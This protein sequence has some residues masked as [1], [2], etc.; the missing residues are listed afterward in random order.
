MRGMREIRKASGRIAFW[1]LLAVVVPV[2]LANAQPAEF[3]DF[4]G[5]VSAITSDKM[6][7]DNRRGDRVS[8]VRSDTTAVTGV[9]QSW[10]AI[11]VGDSVTVSWKMTDQPRIAHKVVVLPAK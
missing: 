9:K 5:T 1:V 10:Q 8:F 7:I 6:V 4:S 2:S 3:R 11:K